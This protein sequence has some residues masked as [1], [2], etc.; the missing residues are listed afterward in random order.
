MSAHLREVIEDRDVPQSQIIEEPAHLGRDLAMGAER[1][2]QRQ[3]QIL[4]QPLIAG[5]TELIIG[6]T[7]DHVFGPL[8][9]FGLYGGVLADRVD[10]RAMMRWGEAGLACCS[11]L[12]LLNAVLGQS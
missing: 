6:V 8:V 3:R 5:G 1:F 2:G 4:V 7:D 11:L 9:V 12:L 10:R